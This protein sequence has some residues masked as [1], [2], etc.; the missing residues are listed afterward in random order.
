MYAAQPR[1]SGPGN[2]ALGPGGLCLPGQMR[3]EGLPKKH[4]FF[5]P[6]ATVAVA[7]AVAESRK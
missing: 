6:G 2:G 4:S 7:L 5:G 1:T 3:S